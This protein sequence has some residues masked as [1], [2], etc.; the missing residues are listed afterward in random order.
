MP[1][2]Y[3]KS[4]EAAANSHPRDAALSGGSLGEDS[5]VAWGFQGD[6]LVLGGGGGCCHKGVIIAEV[7]LRE[8]T[9]S[10]QE[11]TARHLANAHT[12]QLERTVLS[13]K[14]SSCS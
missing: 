11:V 7:P 8:R 1:V 5:T 10:Y 4:K 6:L 2:R 12:G 13:A 14:A 3:G 9:R